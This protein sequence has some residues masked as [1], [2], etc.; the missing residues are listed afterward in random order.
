MLSPMMSN[1]S[2][3][4]VHAERYNVRVWYDGVVR[5]CSLSV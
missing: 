3:Y 1:L 2:V 5:G 4:T